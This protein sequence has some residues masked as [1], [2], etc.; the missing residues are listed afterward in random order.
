M[1][2]ETIDPTTGQTLERFDDHDDDELDRRLSGAVDAHEQLRAA[3]FDERGKWMDTAAD[4]LDAE[5]DDTARMM[6]T[7]MGKPLSQAEAEV[8]KCATALRYYVDHA[9]EFLAP[10]ERDADAVGA[11]RAL[12]MYQPLGPVLAVMPW[13]YPLWQAVRFAAP[14]LMAGNTGVLKHAS[15]V[16]RTAAYL[17]ELFGRAG[18]PDGAFSHLYVGSDRIEGVIADDRI[19]ARDPDRQRGGGPLGR[20]AGRKAPEEGGAGAGRLG[21]V[22]RDAERRPRRRSHD[23]REG[24][25]PEQRAELHR[26]E[27]V[28]RARRRLRRLRRPVRRPDGCPDRRRPDGVEHRHRPARDRAGAAPTSPTAVRDAREGGATVVVGGEVPDRAGWWY[29]PTVLTD[30]APGMTAYD[31]EV[32]G[33]VAALFRVGSYDEAIRVANDTPFGLGS[34]AW[35]A[36]EAEQEAFMRDLDAGM[37]F[38]NG[39]TASFPELAF[40]GVKS[41]GYGRELGEL[42]IRE[43]CNTKTVWVGSPDRSGNE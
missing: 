11:R 26:R 6:T 34:N 10:V 8:H 7:E 3:S 24:A 35:T 19:V 21:P 29:P 41:S 14:A 33:P 38:V 20:G 42:G 30:V 31:D 15:N 4:I 13:N 1:A 2:Y 9:A 16:P 37:V 28:H 32:F 27:A 18:F 36:D 22:R 23:R 43:F 12:T 17:G 5:A 39:F 40:G 25:V